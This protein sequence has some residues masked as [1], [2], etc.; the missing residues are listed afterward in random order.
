MTEVNTPQVTA[1]MALDAI[2]ATTALLA[3]ADLPRGMRPDFERAAMSA[4]A[5]WEQLDTP[6]RPDRYWTIWTADRLEVISQV[7]G[8]DLVDADAALRAATTKPYDFEHTKANSYVVETDRA[9]FDALLEWDALSE[10]EKAP[11]RPA[12]GGV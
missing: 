2:I 12:A 5:L 1:R 10:D 4:K 8:P 3:C 11:L 6:P 9:G 7:C